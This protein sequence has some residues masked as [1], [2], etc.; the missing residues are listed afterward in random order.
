MPQLCPVKD[1]LKEM[2][3]K[4]RTQDELDLLTNE[5]LIKQNSL[6]QWTNRLLKRIKR[7]QG[8]QSQ[9]HIVKLMNCFVKNQQNWNAVKC[10]RKTNDIN[11]H[12]DLKTGHSSSSSSSYPQIQLSATNAE[13]KMLLLPEGVKY[14][15]T[16]ALVN[17]VKRLG[18]CSD[19]EKYLTIP[20]VSATIN[21]DP[22]Q[23]TNPSQST[24][25]KLLQKNCDPSSSSNNASEPKMR[26]HSDEIKQIETTVGVLQTNLRYLESDYDS[27]ATE[28]SSGDEN[29]G[30]IDEYY[31]DPQRRYGSVANLTV[32]L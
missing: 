4:W 19:N 24:L 17:L 9:K 23:T 31:S 29:Y 3:Q 30:D 14:L 32:P 8:K 11:H 18:N 26:F 27:D 25:V 20:N 2:M 1:D 21:L 6:E 12:K 10:Q 7:L 15:S 5:S 28:S 16:S 22:H 13:E